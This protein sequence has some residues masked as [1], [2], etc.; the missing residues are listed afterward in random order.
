MKTHRMPMLAAGMLAVAALGTFNVHGAQTVFKTDFSGEETELSRDWRDVANAAIKE[1]KLRL[2]SGKNEASSCSLTFPRTKPGSPVTIGFTLHPGGGWGNGRLRIGF[3]QGP[4]SAERYLNL[5]QIPAY[6]GVG[7]NGSSG[8]WN[9]KTVGAPGK[10]LPNTQEAVKVKVHLDPA[11]Q[12]MNLMVDGD[13]VLKGNLRGI[14]NLAAVS[15]TF[16]GTSAIIHLDDLVIAGER[17]SP[18]HTDGAS[19][20]KAKADRLISISPAELAKATTIGAEQFNAPVGVATVVADTQADGGKAWRMET[21]KG[22]GKVVSLL[23][24]ISPFVKPGDY[25][26]ILRARYTHGTEQKDGTAF[27][28]S[29]KNAAT[30]ESRSPGPQFIYDGDDGYQDYDF[31]VIEVADKEDW[32]VSLNVNPPHWFGPKLQTVTLF[33]DRLSFIPATSP[34]LAAHPDWRNALKPKGVAGPEWL[35]ADGGKALVQ[36]VI[37]ETA[38]TKEQKAA[39]DLAQWLGRISGAA[40]SVGKENAAAVTGKV[41]SV[42]KTRRWL[43]SGVAQPDLGKDGYGIHAKGNT[44]FIVGGS[45]R[46]IINGVYAFLE[47]DLGCR[48]YHPDF[49]PLIPNLPRLK[50]APVARSFVPPFEMYRIAHFDSTQWAEDWN[51]RNRTLTFS[52]VRK[53]WGGKMTIWPGFAHTYQQLVPKSEFKEH[54]DYFMTDANGKQSSQQFCPTHPEVRKIVLEKTLAALA[55]NP[56]INVVCISPNDGGGYCVC[57]RC[58][59]IID[60]EG[61][62]AYGP[63]LDLCNSL[64]AALRDKYPEVIVQAGG[65]YLEMVEPA[66]TMPMGAKVMYQASTDKHDWAYGDLFFHET[67]VQKPLF[68]KWFRQYPGRCFYIWSYPATFNSMY[69]NC[70]LIP[71]AANVRWYAQQGCKGI[72]F[73][74]SSEVDNTAADH[75]LLR[76]WLYAKLAWNP[77]LDVRELIRDFNY[78]FYGKAATEMQAYDELRLNMWEKWHKENVKGTWIVADKRKEKK[79]GV[80]FLEPEFRRELL[81]RAEALVNA[82]MQAAQGNEELRRRLLH[83]ELPFWYWQLEKGPADPAEFKALVDGF[84]ALVKR[85]KLQNIAIVT[86]GVPYPADVPVKIREYRSWIGEKPPLPG[87]ELSRKW[88]FAPDPADQGMKE[89]WY[90]EGYADFPWK[91]IDSSVGDWTSQGFPKYCGFG[92]YRQKFSVPQKLLDSGK[93]WLFVGQVDEE[94]EVFLNGEPAFTHTAKSTGLTPE[95]LWDKPFV[96]DAT[97]FLK[98]GENTLAVRVYNVANKGGIFTPVW[99]LSQNEAPDP[100][101]L[102][103]QA[104]LLWKLEQL[105]GGK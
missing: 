71:L 27:I 62:A 72:F 7:P 79:S 38:D 41:I 39:A 78:G 49:Y 15:F 75:T 2:G 20:L 55:K 19:L 37:P 58:K 59:A 54:P 24:K 105:K 60:A 82:A 23:D 68:E 74:H 80:A 64:A 45:R 76:P 86:P 98:A 47:E 36:I 48:W 83:A 52:T 100:A 77:D 9:G 4:A 22:K 84:Q 102:L 5:T 53:E 33:V 34:R 31:G 42:G 73:Q 94:A 63:L 57:E 30:G 65:P 1:G 10:A 81:S 96:F 95:K 87:I 13:E 29:M 104:K 67:D 93:L 6:F 14:Q 11:N 92:W 89:L 32:G 35:L 44:L 51:L 70:N 66:R 91:L 103:E 88:K 26:V 61:G 21:E 90:S 28:A 3:G 99:L 17:F 46:G 40:F 43:E 8:Y 69:L 85:A 16:D 97:R 18:S 12:T 101:K 25:R 56:D 50:V